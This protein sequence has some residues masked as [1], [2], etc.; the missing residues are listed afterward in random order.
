MRLGPLALSPWLTLR[1]RIGCGGSRADRR[2]RG[3]PVGHCRD[4]GMRFLLVPALAGS[5][6]AGEQE[7]DDAGQEAA[8]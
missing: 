5:H 4:H 8:R 6:E 3:W 2:G 7:R 1:R